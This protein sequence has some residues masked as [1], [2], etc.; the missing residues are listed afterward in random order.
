MTPRRVVT[1]LKQAGRRNDAGLAEN[2][3]STLR[4]EALRQ[5]APVEHALGVAA[6]GL[7]ETITAISDA[8]A[9]LKAELATLFDQHAQASIITSF[10]GLGPVL[11]AR[12]LGELG[13]DPHRFTDA[14]G[15][16]SFA[17]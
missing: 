13:D 15:M 12:I 8:I 14:R 5:P 2:I 6:I 17:G 7:I 9:A 10:P 11:G 3:S 16:R 4:A 1:L